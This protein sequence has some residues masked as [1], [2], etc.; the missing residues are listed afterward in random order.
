MRFKPES[1]SNKGEMPEA[2]PGVYTME[3]RAY[4]ENIRT[5][6]W[7]GDIV[8]FSDGEV[9][10]CDF[11]D[12]RSLWKY[13]RLAR[14]L[15]KDALESYKSTDAEGFST[16]SPSNFIGRSVCVLVES[17]EAGGKI[18]NR[19][20]K[21]QAAGTNSWDT[22]DLEPETEPATRPGEPKASKSKKAQAK[23]DDDIPF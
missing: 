11:I 8:E 22:E 3:L 15:G 7:S 5:P 4:K 21:I 23:F 6:R 9:K 2:G 10:I 12:E 14:A 1:L 20:K 19:I 18:T 16:F 13:S 17:S